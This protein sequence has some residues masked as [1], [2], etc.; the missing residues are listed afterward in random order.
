MIFN[1][2]LCVNVVFAAQVYL[3]IHDIMREN[4][5]RG[6]LDLRFAGLRVDKIIRNNRLHCSFIDT[7]IH[8]DVLTEKKKIMK[9]YVL[10]EPYALMK[11]DP[12]LCG[13]MA[14]GLNLNFQG[15]GCSIANQCF[16]IVSAAHLYSSARQEG[17]LPPGSQDW[18]DM[19]FLMKTHGARQIFQGAVPDKPEK[20][21]QC[22]ERTRGESVMNWARNRR[23]DRLIKS[24]RGHSKLILDSPVHHLF[25]RHDPLH[26]ILNTSIDNLKQY[27]HQGIKYR[28][29][30]KGDEE[31]G[32]QCDNAHGLGFIELLEFVR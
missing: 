12:W 17:L 29:R 8:R 13:L 5:S 3:N 31:A 11:Q 27:L 20:Y 26:P 32:A 23:N 7:W 15:Y 21:F 22:W 9:R 4:V 30:Q 16:S 28:Q 10:G 14:L 1:R 25:P 19:D 24:K 2:R 6:F 18:P